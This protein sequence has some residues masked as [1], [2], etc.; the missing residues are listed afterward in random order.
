[1]KKTLLFAKVALYVGA[2]LLLVGAQWQ[3][4]HPLSMIAG[5]EFLVG[6]IF[7]LCGGIGDIVCLIESKGTQ[8]L[9]NKGIIEKRKGDAGSVVKV[10]LYTGAAL[11]LIGAQW[12]YLRPES[13][14]AGLVFLIGAISFL[15]GGVADVVYLVKSKRKEAAGV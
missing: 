5:F 11:L 15:C 9:I 13:L 4:G 2:V 12:R 7:L 10:A 3:K 14:N 6:A 1:M 8:E